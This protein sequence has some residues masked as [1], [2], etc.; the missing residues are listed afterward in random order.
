MRA[1]EKRKGMCCLCHWLYHLLHVAATVKASSLAPLFFLSQIMLPVVL[2]PSYTVKS[3]AG[4]SKHSLSGYAVSENFNYISNDY[5]MQLL[6]RH[7]GLGKS[8]P[9]RV[10]H[11]WAWIYVLINVTEHGRKK[12]REEGREGRMEGGRTNSSEKEQVLITASQQLLLPLWA[13]RGILGSISCY[14]EV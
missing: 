7:L 10:L 2:S 6:L 8:T 12:R 5:K 3:L 14:L 4:L 1:R 9:S 13:P 11:P